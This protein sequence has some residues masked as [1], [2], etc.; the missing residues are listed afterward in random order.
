MFVWNE[1]PKRF[2]Y[3]LVSLGASI[4]VGFVLVYIWLIICLVLGYGDSGP[5][6]VNTVTHWIEIGSVVISVTLSQLLFNYVKKKN[7][8]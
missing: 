2:L 5:A 1:V 3:L 8:E 7:A 4:P 6:W